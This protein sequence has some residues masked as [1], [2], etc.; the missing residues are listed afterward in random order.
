[1]IALA[2]T[3]LAAAGVGAVVLLVRY[4]RDF[5]ADDRRYTQ[6]GHRP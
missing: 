6:K 3:A 2:L 4:L 5:T 1:M